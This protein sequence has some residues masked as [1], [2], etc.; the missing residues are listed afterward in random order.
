MNRPLHTIVA[1]VALPPPTHGQAIVNQAVVDALSIAHAPLKVINTSPGVLQRGVNYHLKRLRL[2]ILNAIPA[3]LN[4]QGG[5]VYSVVEPGYGM[6]Y[7]FLIIFF[8]RAKRLRIVLHH[9][10]ALYTKT[11][12]LRFDWLSRLAG[13]GALHVA[14]D[15]LMAEDIRTRYRSVVNVL[16]A[17]NACHVAEFTAEKRDDRPLTCGF[18]SNLS[19]EKGLD[20]FIGCLRMARSTGLNLQAI[21]AGPPTSFE[22][23]KMIEEAKNEFGGA[24]TVLGPVSGARKQWFFKSI[25]VFL[26]PTRYKY[27]GQPLVIL[28]A[29]SY[30]VPVV[31]TNH[32][33]CAQLIGNAGLTALISEFETVATVFLTR[34]RVDADHWREMQGEARNRYNMLKLKAN[35]QLNNL[36]QELCLS[37]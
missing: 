27:E 1:V 23:E 20:T 7:N 14:L 17:H 34:C 29:M 5:L 9:H 35:A 12:D 36:I 28:E 3:I 10:S 6:Y 32:G 26:F 16:V 2:H 11:F 4:T 22:A 33:Y 18:M 13:N 30:G 19:R 31:A 24:L 8:A 15:N 37:R 21:L 25:D